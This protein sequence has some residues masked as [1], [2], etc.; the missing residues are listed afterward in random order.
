MENEIVKVDE[1]QLIVAKDVVKAI[2][3]IENQKKQLDDLQKKYKQQ[4][5]EKMDEYDIKSYESPDK[6]LKISR[7]PATVVTRFDEQRFCKEQHDLYVQ[8]QTDMDRKS[9][10]RIT[11]REKKDNE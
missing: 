2:K 5:L 6:T 10:L 8:Y 4:I 1:G 3:E 9:S 7:T 11:V